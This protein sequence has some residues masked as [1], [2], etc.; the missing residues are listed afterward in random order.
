MSPLTIATVG[1]FVILLAAVVTWS[2]LARGLLTESVARPNESCTFTRMPDHK[3][4]LHRKMLPD[5]MPPDEQ[6]APLSDNIGSS[7]NFK[8]A[9][10]AT[11]VITILSLVALVALVFAE[12]TDQVKSVSGTCEKAFIFGFSALI[13]LIGGRA[14]K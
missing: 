9:L 11:F 6:T 2:P 5:D 10:A 4:V 14:I 1:L 12:P 8:Y 3:V 13:G 7:P